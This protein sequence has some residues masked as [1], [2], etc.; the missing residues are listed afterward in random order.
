[1]SLGE[2]RW[3]G[4]DLGCTGGLRSCQN[5]PS[6]F[7]VRRKSRLHRHRNQ[8]GSEPMCA[9]GMAWGVSPV[10][11]LFPVPPIPPVPPQRQQCQT[12]G[13]LPSRKFQGFCRI[14]SFDTEP[15]F[16]IL[17][18]PEAGSWALLGPGK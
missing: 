18:L 13:F 14:F 2:P 11:L 1:M 17:L 6:G 9:L 15:G 8:L 3:Q 5:S 7:K 16:Q 12:S 4:G 10:S